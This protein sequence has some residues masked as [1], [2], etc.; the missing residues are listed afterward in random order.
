MN[1]TSLVT[2]AGSRLAT[3]DALKALFTG[4]DDSRLLVLRKDGTVLRQLTAHKDTIGGIA[5]LASMGIILSTIS[6]GRARG[7]H[8]G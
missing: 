4:D 1:S 7:Y 2:S 5:V 8:H 6:T 3:T